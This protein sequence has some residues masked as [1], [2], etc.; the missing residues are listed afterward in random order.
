MQSSFF[1]YMTFKNNAIQ[2]QRLKKKLPLVRG[3][4]WGAGAIIF[5]GSPKEN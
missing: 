5:R 3:V 4:L 2:I 1:I